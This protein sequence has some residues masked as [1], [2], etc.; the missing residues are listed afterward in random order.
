MQKVFPQDKFQ[1]T[2]HFRLIFRSHSLPFYVCIPFQ[3]NIQEL[4]QFIIE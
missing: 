2:R 1:R 3:F 4:G